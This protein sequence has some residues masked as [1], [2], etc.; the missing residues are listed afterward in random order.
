MMWESKEIPGEET[1]GGLESD[2]IPKA[3][4]VRP[5]GVTAAETASNGTEEG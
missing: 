1:L 4:R 3:G 5:A 2:P